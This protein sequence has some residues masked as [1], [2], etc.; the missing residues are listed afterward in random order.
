[1]GILSGPID[2]DP[3]KR[4]AVTYRAVAAR[5][6]LVVTHRASGVTGT[7]VSLRAAQ[8]VVRDR[9]GR[10][11][12]FRTRDGDFVVDGKPVALR[13]P[14]PAAEPAAKK[15]TASG[16]IDPGAVPA[17]MARASRIYVEGLHDAELVE[18]VWGDDL[19][20]EGVV[21]EY[22]SGMDDLE[23]FVRSF[24]PRPNRRLGVLLDHL[25]TGTKETRAADQVTHPDVLVT[26]HPYVDIWQAVKPKVIGIDAWPTVPMGQP[27]KEG[28]CVALGWSGTTGEFWKHLLGKVRSFTDLEPGLV[29]AVEQLIDFVA[30]PER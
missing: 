22:L 11:H 7:L 8:T 2:M 13:P 25:V 17:R 4:K 28:V 23:T 16:S 3:Q 15:R 12:T 9:N 5:P 21:V 20:V 18:K 29:G 1:M 26:G 24:G 19:R 27:W 30:P 10:D 14:K 6:G